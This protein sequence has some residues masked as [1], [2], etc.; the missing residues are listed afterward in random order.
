MPEWIGTLL[1]LGAA[2]LSGSKIVEDFRNYGLRGYAVLMLL[3]VIY[4]AAIGA[5]FS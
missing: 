2:G 1:F 3:F 4:A 5:A